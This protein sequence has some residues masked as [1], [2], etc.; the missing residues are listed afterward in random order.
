MIIFYNKKTKKI[1]GTVDG[2]VHSEHTLKHSMIKT[3][4]MKNEDV[5]K[6][7]IPFEKNFVMREVE[8]KELRVVDKARRVKE[9]VVGKKKKKIV[10]GLKLDKPFAKVIHDYENRKVK[11]T[12]YKVKLDK[13]GEVIDLI[14]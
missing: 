5:G 1:I 10:E 9:V 11:M 6:Y 3:S 13:Q 14:K 8:I 7:V 2:R 12:D 4:A